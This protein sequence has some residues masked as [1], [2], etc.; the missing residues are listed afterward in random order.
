MCSSPVFC[1]VKGWCSMK[2]NRKLWIVSAALVAVVLVAALCLLLPRLEQLGV[3][4]LLQ[5][6]ITDISEE[7][8]ISI[9]DRFRR[10]KEL[11]AFD[12]IVLALGY[13]SDLSIH[14]MLEDCGIPVR[15]V[16][17]SVH[18]GKVITAVRSAFETAYG[19]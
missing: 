5:C 15:Y 3:S 14:P 13:R 6:E 7:G 11:P 8:R 17:D 12:S 2:K 10:E 1:F 19:I 16:G 4:S 9:R 18:A